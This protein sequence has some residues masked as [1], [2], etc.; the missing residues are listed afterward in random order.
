MIRVAASL[1]V[2]TVE[3]EFARFNR[4]FRECLGNAVGAKLG[5]SSSTCMVAKHPISLN[6]LPP[7]PIPAPITLLYRPP[8]SFNSFRC[9][10]DFL[11]GYANVL[12]DLIHALSMFSGL[13]PDSSYTLGRACLF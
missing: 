10:V 6:A 4:A 11:G 7:L 1:V 3:D 12:G 2:A 9:E 8:E 13:V 5:R